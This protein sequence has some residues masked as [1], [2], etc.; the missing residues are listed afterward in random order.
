MGRS[1]A[2]PNVLFASAARLNPSRGK[3][4]PELVTA[5]RHRRVSRSDTLER[6][7]VVHD[8]NGDWY[9]HRSRSDEGYESN[10]SHHSQSGDEGG[11]SESDSA[12]TT[13]DD[14]DDIE[15]LLRD[16]RSRRSL[17]EEQE[18]EEYDIDGQRFAIRLPKLKV[19]KSLAVDSPND[20][21]RSMLRVKSSK[22]RRRSSKF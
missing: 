13:D 6:T 21:N 11:D 5:Y 12:C 3:T 9:K 7:F 16:N 22:G 17:E 8:S 19:R 14:G 4:D 1:P 18:Q 10:Y 15:I 20:L 2:T